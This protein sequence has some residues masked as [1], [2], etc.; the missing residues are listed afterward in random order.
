MGACDVRHCAWKVR[1]LW[2]W[3]V[4]RTRCV[5]VGFW[6]WASDPLRPRACPAHTHGPLTLIRKG[7]SLIIHIY[8]DIYTKRLPYIVQPPPSFLNVTMYMCVC[9]VS[10]IRYS[11][12]LLR[13]GSQAFHSTHPFVNELISNRQVCFQKVLR[14]SSGLEQ[15][16]PH[17]LENSDM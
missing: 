5:W 8:I 14:A 11:L 16:P 6:Y 7:R 15:I 9:T 10:I 3:L 2:G 12:F 1:V 4:V 17:M 13:V